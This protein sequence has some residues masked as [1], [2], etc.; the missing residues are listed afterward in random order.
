MVEYRLGGMDAADYIRSMRESYTKAGVA[1]WAARDVRESFAALAELEEFGKA[2]TR[3]T[4]ETRAALTAAVVDD[5]GQKQAD[6]AAQLGMTPSRLSQLVQRGRKLRRSLHMS[7]AFTLPEPGHLGV[8]I[9]TGP[10]GVLLVQRKD[11]VPPWSFPAT[12]IRTGE[13]PGACVTRNVPRETGI[14]VKPTELLGRRIHPRTGWVMTYVACSPISE[15]APA[16][17]DTDDLSA[18]RWMTLDETLQVMKELF[19]AAKEHL[20]SVLGGR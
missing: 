1:V 7:E 12:E 13:S 2:V 6:L 8:A 10:E 19:P 14:E 3:E 17:L 15:Q 4:A 11:G 20:L 16:L 18:V 9:V 5:R